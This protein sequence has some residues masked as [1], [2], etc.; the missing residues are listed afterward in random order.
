MVSFEHPGC[1]V[2]GVAFPSSR[3]FGGFALDPSHHTPVVTGFA[4]QLSPDGVVA[5]EILAPRYKAPDVEFCTE[6]DPL[7]RVSSTAS[8]CTMPLLELL[9]L[10]PCPDVLVPFEA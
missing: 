3:L 6:A 2:M 9:F 7:L 5:L 10:A 1:K 8:G 4:L